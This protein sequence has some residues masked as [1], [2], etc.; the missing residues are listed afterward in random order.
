MKL[1]L[2]NDV[3]HLYFCVKPKNQVTYLNQMIELGLT[4]YLTHLLSNK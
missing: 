1:D 2:L 4:T 3:Y